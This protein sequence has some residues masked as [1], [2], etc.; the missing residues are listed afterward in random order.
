MKKAFALILTLTLLLSLTPVALAAESLDNFVKTEEYTADTFSDVP[1]KAW[2]QPSVKT[3]YEL[4]LVKGTSATKFSPSDNISL[5]QAIT[6]AARIHSIYT[7]GSET[8][9]QGKPWYQVYVDYA[10]SNGIITA[11]QFNNY[12]ATATRLQF[13]S[14]LY[15]ALPE[16]AYNEINTIEDGAVPD[17]DIGSAYSKEIYTFYRAG[18]LTG[19]DKGAFHPA[20]SI[21]R[22]EVAAIIARMVDVSL[23]KSFT[24]EKA[25]TTITYFDYS[26]HGINF[27]IPSFYTNTSSAGD[28][29]N[30][31]FTTKSSKSSLSI[32]LFKRVAENIT[33]SQYDSVKDMLCTKFVSSTSDIVGTPT[34][35]DYLVGTQPGKGVAYNMKYEESG[36]P[37]LL[38]CKTVFTYSPSTKS[39]ICFTVAFLGDSEADYS[40]EFDKMLK[41]AAVDAVKDDPSTGGIRPGFK[42]AMDS[43]EAFFD[44]YVAFMKKFENGNVSAD[45]YIEYLSLL[46]E[47]ETTMSKLQE[48]EEGEMST[49]ELAYYTEV[50][51]RINKKLATIA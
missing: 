32:L 39:V 18:I 38:T 44:K 25:E 20:S 31:T 22:S 7:T 4:G 17:V 48:I 3:C 42:E 49:E 13:V 5:A 33:P 11:N 19:S 10:I 21:M 23:R 1:E 30:A 29:D 15:N 8:F 43:F 6:F 26:F 36:I 51:A 9:V 12:D 41:S 2:F 40:A 37:L 35:Y 45:A 47:Y 50:M 28:E 34:Y 27:K 24:L 16:S 14:I 46:N